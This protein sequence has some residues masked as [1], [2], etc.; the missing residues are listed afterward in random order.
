MNGAPTILI[1]KM[2]PPGVRVRT[3]QRAMAPTCDRC[4]RT[5][6]PMNP[7]MLSE[8]KEWTMTAAG[9]RAPTNAVRRDAICYECRLILKGH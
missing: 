2:I 6:T 1:P 8:R 5:A 3:G 9:H 4:R 7:V